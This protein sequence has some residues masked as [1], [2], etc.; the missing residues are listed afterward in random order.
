MHKQKKERQHILRSYPNRNTPMDRA[1]QI[2]VIT[3]IT[4]RILFTAGSISP[5]DL[6]WFCGAV[7]ML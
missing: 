2:T 4:D 5:T 1:V 6:F 3:V 7:K